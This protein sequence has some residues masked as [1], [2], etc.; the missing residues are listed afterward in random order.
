[1]RDSK[2]KE[3]D[4]EGSLL[5]RVEGFLSCQQSQKKK[6]KKISVAI[7]SSIRAK[8]SLHSSAKAV[9]ISDTPHLTWYQIS[10]VVIYTMRFYIKIF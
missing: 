9:L 10:V 3:T 8:Q 1:M 5:I 6:R 7:N 4:Q 2:I